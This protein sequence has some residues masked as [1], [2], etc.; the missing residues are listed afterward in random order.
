ME[1]DTECT[2]MFYYKD[3]WAAWSDEDQKND[4]TGLKIWDLEELHYGVLI[5][6]RTI[7]FI[8]LK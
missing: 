4:L 5:T 6:T 7:D 1:D 3:N 8:T 2:Y